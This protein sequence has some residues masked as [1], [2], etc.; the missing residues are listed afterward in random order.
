DFRWTDPNASP[1]GWDVEIVEKGVSPS[2]TPS[3]IALITTKQYQITDLTPSTFYELYIR[4]VCDDTEKS[5][6]NGPFVVST[7]LENPSACGIGLDIKDN[8]TETFLVDIEDTGKLG[9]DLFIESVELIVEHEWPAD[10]MISLFNPAGQS[11][12]LTRYHG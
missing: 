7:V 2:G 4:T 9:Q 5:A 3:N 6:W 11:T 10:V 8:G 12:R 1:M